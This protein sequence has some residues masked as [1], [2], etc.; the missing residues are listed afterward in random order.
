MLPDDPRHGEYAGAVAHW[1]AGEKPCDPCARAG[2]RYHKARQLRLLRGET[3]TVPA[4]GTVRRIQALQA[5]GWGIPALARESGLPVPTLRNPAYRGERVRTAT[6]DRV[7]AMYER[8]AMVRPDGMYAER[9][10]RQ[11]ARKGWLPPLAWT[12]IDDPDE[13]P[14]LT[15][16]DDLPDP[17]VVDRI[18]AGDRTLTPTKAERWE[19]IRRWPGSDKELERIFGWNV[20]RDR[21]EMRA[22]EGA[23]N[24]A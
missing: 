7:S 4:V 17:V 6:A 10:R 11:A 5:L 14:D 15:A 18:L 24:A 16:T 22:G 23:G 3:S 21:R 13:H 19:V 8:L 9:S 12:D 1:L 20:A 2:A